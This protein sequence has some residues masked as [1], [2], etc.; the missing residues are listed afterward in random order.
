VLI[1]V[2]LGFALGFVFSMPVAGPVS[3]LVFGRGLQGRG[4]S[5]VSL[6]LGSSIAESMYAYLAFW[7]FSA[8]LASYAWIEPL[9]RALTCVLLTALGVRFARMHTAAPSE[10][11]TITRELGIKRSFFLGLTITALNPTLIATWSAV[12]AGVHSFELIALGAQHALVFAVGVGCGSA[13]WFAVLLW[14]L[15]RYKQRFPAATLDRTLRYMGLFAVALG[16]FFGVRFVLYF[17]K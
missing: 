16:L 6:A 3:L 2:V 10:A 15:R 13:V 9:S 11:P 14:L 17:Q 7:G 4:R 12:A 5:G 8:L 1:A